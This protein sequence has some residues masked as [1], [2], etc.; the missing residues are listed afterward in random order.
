MAD[1]TTD[2]GLSLFE[3]A[4]KM[5]VTIASEHE[6]EDK[7]IDVKGMKI[8][9]LDWGNAGAQPMLLLHGGSQ[10]C[11]MWDF[12]GLA[13]H[14]DYHIISMD[15]RGHGDSGWT[16]DGTYSTQGH[17][18]DIEGLV[19]QLGLRNI[20]LSGLSMGGINSMAY[21]GAHPDNVD[22]LIIV[23]AAPE[24]KT[25][26]SERVNRFR[27]PL[28]DI[29]GSYEDLVQHVHKFNPLRPIQ[30]LRGSL[31][32]SVKQVPDGSWTWR[33]DTRFHGQR[34]EG[35]PNSQADF[36]WGSVS[37]IKCKT[38]LVMAEESVVE[39]DVAEKL[40]GVLPAGSRRVTVP[41]TSHLVVGD[42]P[43]GFEKTA[44]DFLSEK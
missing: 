26:W 36:L 41:K 9:Y 35:T 8:H 22:R 42:N 34:R 6:P 40:I 24:V 30:Q 18:Q 38:L 16:E 5:G 43:A 13:F 44:R 15:Q 31:R 1:T 17:L 29:I 20:V 37:R 27:A 28:G 21:T 33:Q 19:E 14:K 23:D 4:R 3:A 32:Y 10:Q 12:V 2:F 39:E 11:H 25:F 7:Y